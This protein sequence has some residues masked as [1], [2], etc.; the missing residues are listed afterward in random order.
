MASTWP[1]E[2][3]CPTCKAREGERCR[4]LTSGRST[5]THEQRWELRAVKSRSDLDQRQRDLLV[6]IAKK[7]AR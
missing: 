5:D 4:T 1:L 7:D 2:V 6:S 3:R